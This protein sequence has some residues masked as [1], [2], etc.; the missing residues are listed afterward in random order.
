MLQDELPGRMVHA[1]HQFVQ[2]FEDGHPVAPSQRRRQEC[3]HFDVFT[4]RET[5]G[6]RKGVVRM[7][8]GTS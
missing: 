5:V 2:A 1:F 6:H 3:R 7:K 8:S 4:A